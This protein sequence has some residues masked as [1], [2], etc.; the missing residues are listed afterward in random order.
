MF[1]TRWYVE[2][3]I[4]WFTVGLEDHL[5]AG[6]ANKDQQVKED[7]A[8]DV[9]AAGPAQA[10]PSIEVMRGCVSCE[11]VV[12][13]PGPDSDAIINELSEKWEA[14]LVAGNQVFYFEE[15]DIEMS[16]VNWGASAHGISLKQ[17]V[18]SDLKMLLHMILARALKRKTTGMH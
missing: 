17:T 1:C 16:V 7:K 13:L 8:V 9:A 15:T 14:G 3:E 11:A 18:L 2:I 10:P 5:V 4:H 12:W 6:K